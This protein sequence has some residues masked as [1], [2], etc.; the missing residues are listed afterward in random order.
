MTLEELNRH[1]ALR[2]QLQ[3][4]K[5]ILASLESRA[6]PGGQVLTGMPHAP[7]VSNKVEMYAVEIADFKA[8]IDEL[9][10]E[11]TEQ[12]KGIEEWIKTVPP[13]LRLI[14]RLRFLR[15]M[16]WKEVAYMMGNS[17]TGDGVYRTVHNYFQQRSAAGRSV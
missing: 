9:E 16:Q 14:F 12:Q 10:T 5:E 8:H 7:G 3:R 15:A 1:L 2:Q 13:T 17:Y 6:V 4:D 11:I